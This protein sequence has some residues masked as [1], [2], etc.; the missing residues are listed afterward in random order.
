[1]LVKFSVQNYRAIRE[2]QTFSMIADDIPR[3]E[4]PYHVAN[5]G[6]AGVPHVLRDACLF[7]GNGAGKTSLVEAMAFMSDFVRTSSN[8]G[9]NDEISTRP[10]IFHPKWSKSPSEFEVVFI[11][12]DTL[13]QYGFAVTQSRVVEEWLSSRS[14]LKHRWRRLFERKYNSGGKSY[15]WDINSSYVKG[16]KTSWSQNTRSNALFLSTSVQLNAKGDLKQAHDWIVKCFNMLSMSTKQPGFKYTVGRFSEKTWKKKALNFLR[17]IGID[18][19]D[20]KVEEKDI[21]DDSVVAELP[22]FMK[23]LVKSNREFK[24]KMIDVYFLRDRYRGVPVPLPIDSESSG[25]RDLFGLSGPIIDTLERGSVIVIDELN[26]GLHP[27]ALQSLIAM[28]CDPDTNAKNAQIVFTTH[29]ASIVENTFSKPD[30]VWLLD[31]D[32]ND[33]TARLTSLA[34]FRDSDTKNFAKDYLDGRYGGVPNPWRQ[35]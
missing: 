10:F 19:S 25:T 22:E 30:Q 6:F 33:L 18:L 4:P 11:H 15:D 26:L 28:F 7:G 14:K 8:K 13:Y 12:N 32:S 35:L 21:H 5:T 16:A 2:R 24:G 1:M 31:K 23:N 9:A 17:E 29:D 27:V 20:I 34:E 3:L